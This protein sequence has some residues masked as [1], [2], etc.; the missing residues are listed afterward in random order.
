MKH[1]MIKLSPFE[2]QKCSKAFPQRLLLSCLL[3]SWRWHLH[4]GSNN[5]TEICFSSVPSDELTNEHAKKKQ[6]FVANLTVRLKQKCIIDEILHQFAGCIH[7]RWLARFSPSTV[8]HIIVYCYCLK[9]DKL[10]LTFLFHP[11]L[12]V[13]HLGSTPPPKIPVTIRTLPFLVMQGNP[14]IMTDQPTFLNVPRSGLKKSGLKGNSWLIS[15][16]HKALFPVGE[17]SRVDY[18]HRCLW[19]HHGEESFTTAWAVSAM[20]RIA[21]L[22]LS[23]QLGWK[24]LESIRHPKV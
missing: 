20:T 21:W 2:Y 9:F 17:A 8:L 22:S 6:T 5:R 13:S 12:K 24:C 4:N 15:P 14:I 16:D 23:H 10:N 11:I 19:G 7:P 3:L 18:R 1:G